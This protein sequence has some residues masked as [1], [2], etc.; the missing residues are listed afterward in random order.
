MAVRGG[1]Q[2]RR[3]AEEAPQGRGYLR[4]RLRTVRPAAY[5]HLRRG[6]AHHDGAACLPRAHRRQGEDAADRL[7]RRHGRAAQSPRQHPREGDGGAPSRQAADEG[8]R[9]VRHASELRR[10]QQC[11]AARLSRRVRLRLR[12]PVLDRLLSL[13]PL[14]RDAPQSARTLRPGDDHHAA[15]AARG[16]RADLFAVPAGL[17]AHRR[18]AAGRRSSRATSRRARSPTTIPRP[19]SG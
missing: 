3:A 11:A 18:R 12:V 4:D 15:V 14:R 5:R 2:G 13:G 17:P 19:A 7:F 16:A 9:S 8:A 10:A 1:A 6:R